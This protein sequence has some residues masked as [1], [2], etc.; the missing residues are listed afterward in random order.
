MEINIKITS[1]P[2][3]ILNLSTSDIVY[4]NWCTNMCVHCYLIAIVTKFYIMSCLCIEVFLNVLHPVA[5]F[6]QKGFME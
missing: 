3:S 5:L 6:G 1:K 2:S 4:N